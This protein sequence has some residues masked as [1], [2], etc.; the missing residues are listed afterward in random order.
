MAVTPYFH[1]RV[2]MDFCS[3]ICTASGDKSDVSLNMDI[4]V[5]LEFTRQLA[6]RA[7]AM[8]GGSDAFGD[9]DAFG[10]SLAWT[11]PGVGRSSGGRRR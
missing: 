10:V 8:F 11:P 2:A 5:N 1:P 6:F 9:E 3:E 4:G 7:S